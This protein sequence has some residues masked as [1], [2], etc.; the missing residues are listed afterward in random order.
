MKEKK[1]KRKNQEE[2]IEERINRN[3]KKVKKKKTIEEKGKMDKK[4]EVACS[5]RQTRRQ[6]G[7]KNKRNLHGFLNDRHNIT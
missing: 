1:Q 7:K 5:W 6:A 2:E 4:I 3:K